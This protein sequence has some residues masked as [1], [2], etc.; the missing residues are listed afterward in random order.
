MMSARIVRKA[1]F[2]NS[3]RALS[4]GSPAYSKIGRENKEQPKPPSR[5]TFNR[6]KP[7]LG[8][9]CCVSCKMLSLKRSFRDSIEKF[10]SP[11]PLGSANR[12]LELALFASSQVILAT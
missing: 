9:L 6:L 11:T 8:K 7:Q 5:G 2:E 12:P 10:R 3:T 1:C 4:A